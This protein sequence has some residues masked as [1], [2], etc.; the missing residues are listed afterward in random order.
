M[1][2]RDDTA[3]TGRFKHLP[4]RVKPEDMTTAQPATAAA[5]PEGG[6]DTERDFMLRY[7]AGG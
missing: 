6:R 7:G 5:D 4:E 2:E 3:D 1:D